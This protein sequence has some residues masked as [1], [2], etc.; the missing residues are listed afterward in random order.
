MNIKIFGAIKCFDTKK[1]ERYFTSVGLYNLINSTAKD[2]L[3]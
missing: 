2:R 3:S 1:A